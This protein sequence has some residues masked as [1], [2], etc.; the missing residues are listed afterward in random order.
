M[1]DYQGAISDCSKA[2]EF[3]PKDAKAYF[4]RGNAKSDLSDYPGAIS[5]Y[6]KA[7]EFDPK[8]AKAYFNREMLNQI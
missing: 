1:E 6:S 2:I 8:D 5:D 3:D 4:I 7:I